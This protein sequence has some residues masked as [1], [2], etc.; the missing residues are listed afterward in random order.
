MNFNASPIFDEKGNISRVVA[1]VEDITERVRIEDELLSLNQRLEERAGELAQINAQLERFAFI[2]SHDLKE[3]LNIISGYA[4]L[5][6][7]K[8]KGKLDKEADEFI[9]FIVDDVSR[10]YKLINS[11]LQIS[12]VSTRGRNF[13]SVSANILVEKA[14]SK[15]R[16]RIMENEAEIFCDVLPEVLVDE[17]QMVQVFLNLID[18]AIRFRKEEP[19]KIQIKAEPEN[20]KWVFTITDNGIGIEA[21]YFGLI[22]Q[23][24]QHIDKNNE[25]DGAGVGLPV[26]RKII[27]RHGGDIWLTSTPGEGSTFYFSLPKPEMMEQVYQETPQDPD[28]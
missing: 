24:F 25:N 5:L 7:R 11:L 14:Q 20:G 26:C 6:S 8:Y 16:R 28:L 1:S 23:L 9:Q 27:N 3:P 19:P 12:R 15:L 10:M 13:K 4:K 17:G 2:A 18:N 21:K 22:F